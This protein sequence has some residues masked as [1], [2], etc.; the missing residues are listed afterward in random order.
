MNK[1]KNKKILIELSFEWENKYFYLKH[2]KGP[3][4]KVKVNLS[5]GLVN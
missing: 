5:L 3:Y 1:N 4:V 2:Y